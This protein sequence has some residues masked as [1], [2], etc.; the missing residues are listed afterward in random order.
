MARFA[1]KCNLS[2][3]GATGLHFPRSRFCRPG[4]AVLQIDGFWGSL[5]V[6]VRSHVCYFLSSVLESWLLA[7]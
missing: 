3:L 4:H 7:G 5:L 6:V 2:T 1:A